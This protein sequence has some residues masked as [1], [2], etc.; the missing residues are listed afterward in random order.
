M[1]T[2]KHT[3]ALGFRERICGT[4]YLRDAVNYILEE[5]P[6]ER[7]K[8]VKEVYP[9]VAEKYGKRW[10]AIERAIRHT[11]CKCESAEFWG[12]N[13]DVIWEL[14]QRCRDGEFDE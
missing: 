7:P 1:L 2:G 11:I 12:T 4:A 5:S 3:K 6:G 9:A 8:L 10:T 14:V 13:A